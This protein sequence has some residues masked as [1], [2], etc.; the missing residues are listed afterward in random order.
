[1]T[2]NWN[3]ASPVTKKFVL[4]LVCETK[5]IMCDNYIGF[6]LHGSLAMGG[7]N[8]QSSDL[9]VLVVTHESIT[10]ETKRKLAKLYF[11]YSTNPYPIEISFLTKGQLDNWEHPSP[12]EF[13][14]S[15]FWRDRYE[16]DLLENRFT[17]LNDDIKTDPDLAAHITIMFYRGICI[18]G[19][20]I[21]EVF[22][23]I[24]SS[25]Y[26]SSIIG[27]YEECLANI[28]DDP[29]YCSLNM[30]R[31]FWY[32]KEG[33]ISS[34]QEAGNWGLT[35]LPDEMKGTMYKVVNSYQSEKSSY[36]FDETELIFLRNYIHYNLQ[37]LFSL[38]S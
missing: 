9:D 30:L 3:D 12:Y 10:I 29:I 28:V 23:R 15:E 14:Y 36:Q 37:D 32:V 38:T 35:S 5:Q 8:P 31:V 1:M 34:K 6:Y 4:D 11:N 21:F 22:P 26:L 7:F 2:Y 16:V 18:E 24:P 20:S 13:H 19:S 27:D 33:I 17:Y 25:D